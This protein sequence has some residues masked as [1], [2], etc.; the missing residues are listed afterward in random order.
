MLLQY[1]MARAY[2]VVC[3]LLRVVVGIIKGPFGKAISFGPRFDI[4]R[5]IQ[6]L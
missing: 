4:A 5:H 6:Q 1:Y 3:L 2:M